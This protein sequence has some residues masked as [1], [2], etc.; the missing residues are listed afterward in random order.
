VGPWAEDLSSCTTEGPRTSRA[1]K[2]DRNNIK[3]L[4]LA[5]SVAF[6]R[7]DYPGAIEHWRRMLPLTSE[8]SRLGKSVRASVAGAQ[9]RMEAEKP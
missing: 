4:A 2:A 5:A 1:L 8:Q 9:K 7:R 6:D 3:A